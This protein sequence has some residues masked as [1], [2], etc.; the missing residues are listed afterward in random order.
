MGGAEGHTGAKVFWSSEEGLAASDSGDMEEFI[1]E[2][3]LRP[4][5][6][7]SGHLKA[8]PGKRAAVKKMEGRGTQS[9]TEALGTLCGVCEEGLC[10]GQGGRCSQE[11]PRQSVADTCPH[12]PGEGEAGSGGVSYPEKHGERMEHSGGLSG[13]WESGPGA[14]KP[15]SFPSP[16]LSLSPLLFTVPLSFSQAQKFG[17]P[18]SSLLFHLCAFSYQILVCVC[19]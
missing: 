16:L 17:P 5:W 13:S 9:S 4:T 19:F 10:A 2:T 6:I 3:G 8:G 15:T 18:I 7:Q 1:R 12:R 11:E 14:H